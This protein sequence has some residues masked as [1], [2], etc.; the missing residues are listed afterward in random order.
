MFTTA[1]RRMSFLP[2]LVDEGRTHIQLRELPR[3]ALLTDLRRLC[4]R[5]QLLG[6]TDVAIDYH[7]F[8]PTGRAYLTLAHTDNL[9]KNLQALDKASVGSLPIRAVS[10]PPPRFSHGRLY[11]TETQ[12]KVF[13]G[14]GP[15]G[16]ILSRMK[17]VVVWG[18]PGKISGEA[19]E[20]YLRDFRL[21]NM[22][23]KSAAVKVELPTNTFSLYSRYLVRPTSTAEAHRLVRQLHMSYYEPE[24]WGKRYQLRARVV[25]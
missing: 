24:Q 6:V 16:G 22:D 23:G 9:H 12:R 19:V 15:H 21:D 20:N 4:I 5:N 1:I 11:K 25:Y 3:S 13:A 8:L 10:A 7:R 14:N 18:L 2:R 17:H